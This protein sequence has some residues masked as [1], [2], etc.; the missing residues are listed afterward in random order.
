[1]QPGHYTELF[2]LD[3]VTALADGHRPCAECRNAEYRTFQ[4]AWQSIYPRQPASADAMDTLLHVER[5]IRPFAKRTSISEIDVLPDGT[6]VALEGSAWLVH[7]G[8]LLRWTT[9]GY[10]ERAPR[11]TARRVT[12]L[13]PPSVVAVLRAGYQPGVHPSVSSGTL[14]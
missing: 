13:T 3:E 1:M 2:F 14:E 7:A 10:T 5:R 4:R 9:A 11:P 8:H 12:V 6:F